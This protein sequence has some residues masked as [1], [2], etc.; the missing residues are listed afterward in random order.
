M[1]MKYVGV[2]TKGSTSLIQFHCWF[3]HPASIFS[4]DHGQIIQYRIAKN[5]QTQATVLRYYLTIF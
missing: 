1:D 4:L 2:M 3:V 5:V